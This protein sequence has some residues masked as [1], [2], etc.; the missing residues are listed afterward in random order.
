MEI[1]ILLKLESTDQDKIEMIISNNID[2]MYKG[3]AAVTIDKWDNLVNEILAWRAY[4]NKKLLLKDVVSS[5]ILIDKNE[6]L[7]LVTKAVKEG[8]N[9]YEVVESGLESFDAKVMA[10]WIINKYV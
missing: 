9:T 6:L 3:K 10:R 1:N 7:K 5:K 2:L 4:E 8:F